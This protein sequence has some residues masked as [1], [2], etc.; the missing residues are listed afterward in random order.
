MSL[1]FTDGKEEFEDLDQFMAAL[2]KQPLLKRV[3]ISN[4]YRGEPCARSVTILCAILEAPD[5]LLETKP[6]ENLLLGSIVSDLRQVSDE[7]GR[8][9]DSPRDLWH[10][11][12]KL[13]IEEWKQIP[14]TIVGQLY[15]KAWA[16]AYFA[17]HIYEN[18]LSDHPK[19]PEKG[20]DSKASWSI[21]GLANTYQKNF[22]GFAND[23]LLD[24]KESL[25]VKFAIRH[26]LRVYGRYFEA[27][28]NSLDPDKFPD[29]SVW[30]IRPN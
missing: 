20:S 4:G 13:D 26:A 2:N 22:L 16:L 23:L 1:L 30:G 3:N 5:I 15:F 8:Y 6:Q 11:L 24:N 27:R 9:H 17:Y 29:F 25:I 19:E 18:E 7:L 10:T 21:Q 12:I 14:M 28:S